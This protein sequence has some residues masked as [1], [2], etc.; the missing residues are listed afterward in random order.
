ML[1]YYPIMQSPRYTFK[2]LLN[3]YIISLIINIY[4][5]TLLINYL[6]SYLY[7]SNRILALLS[8]FAFYSLQLSN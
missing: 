3:F 6:I 5:I 8:L 1:S 2:F 7:I 4:L